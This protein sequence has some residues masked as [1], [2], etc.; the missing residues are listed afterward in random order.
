[1]AIPANVTIIPQSTLPE[2]RVPSLQPH[3]SGYTKVQAGTVASSRISLLLGQLHELANLPEG[4]DSGEG[5]PVKQEVIQ[6]AKK[7]CER[8]ADWVFKIK[9]FPCADG[10]LNLA[11]CRED[12]F[13]EVEIDEDGTFDVY[14]ETGKGDDCKLVKHIPNASVED[15]N[16]ELIYIILEL[17]WGLSESSITDTMMQISRNLTVRVSRP[18]AMEREFQSSTPNVHWDVPLPYADILNAF[19]LA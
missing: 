19:T 2:M 7:L 6:T 11:F 3:P 4:W 17:E 1:M 16:S 9:M 18:Q 10:T 13:L 14:K 5:I 8:T 15:V 12:A